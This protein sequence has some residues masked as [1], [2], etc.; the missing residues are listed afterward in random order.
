MAQLGKISEILHL[1]ILKT[2]CLMEDLIQGWTQLAPFFQ[3]QSTFFDW[4]GPGRPCSPSPPLVARLLQHFASGKLGSLLKHFKFWKNSCT[5]NH[6]QIALT[7]SKQLEAND[8]YP[9]MIF[10]HL[11][12]E[13]FTKHE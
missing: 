8:V 10:S 9:Q 6:F 13:I 3:N 4:Q 11:Q 1:D 5:C 2:T 12:L 7:F